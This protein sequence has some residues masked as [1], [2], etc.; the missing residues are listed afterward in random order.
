MPQV[1][2][3]HDFCNRIA[4]EI[5]QDNLG[6]GTIGI[7]KRRNRDSAFGTLRLVVYPFRMVEHVG[8]GRHDTLIQIAE[9]IHDKD[10]LVRLVVK[11]DSVTPQLRS[12]VEEERTLASILGKRYITGL[13]AT[14]PHE[15]L[16]SAVSRRSNPRTQ[17]GRARN[18]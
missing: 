3:F 9:A 5:N 12:K 13:L 7:G 15:V 4:M 11:P 14:V 6:M 16:R 2:A 10:N 18:S 8:L 17:A 1:L